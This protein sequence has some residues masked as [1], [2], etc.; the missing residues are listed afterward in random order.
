[1]HTLIVE[2]YQRH[3]EPDNSIVK[4]MLAAVDGELPLEARIVRREVDLGRGLTDQEIEHEIIEFHS[5]ARKQ[6]A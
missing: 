3:P 4:L 2:R 5:K 6:A 1:M